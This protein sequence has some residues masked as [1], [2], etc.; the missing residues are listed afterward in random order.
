MNN[1]ALKD[2]FSGNIHTDAG[3]YLNNILLHIPCYIYWKNI[4]FVYLGC[5]TLFAKAA[6]FTSP[7]EIIGKTDYDLAWGETEADL[8]QQSDKEVLSG[9]YKL[10]F[11]EP[12][13]Q[14]DGTTKTVLASKVPML[15]QKGKIIGILGIYIDITK[16][17]QTEELEREK[18]IAEEK[19]E[20]MKMLAASIAHELRTPLAS[21]NALSGV[22]RN[23]LP[24]LIQSY[25]KALA[26]GVEVD[27]LS[28]TILNAL[29]DLPDDFN[30]IINSANTFINMLLAKVNSEKA[31]PTELMPLSIR[32]CVDKALQQYPFSAGE[33]RLIYW[34]TTQDF[35]FKGDQ[36]LMIYV[37]F[38]LLKNALHYLAVAG[39]GEIRIWIE[40]HKD[41]NLLH[42]KDTAKGINSEVLPYIFEQFY[43]KTKHGTGVG[44]AFCKMV[45]NSFGGNISCESKENEY[46]HF[47]LK[48][49]ISLNKLLL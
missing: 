1:S 41:Y 42:F 49:P 21:I 26:E 25:Q 9:K 13:L 2:Q 24:V 44:L 29:I 32:E 20:T 11:E 17:K 38:N 7:Q 36:L 31:K 43:S 37:L 16:K 3:I 48:F 47:M 39:K 45:M 40:K 18:A 5:N 12:Q 46:A 23:A 33:R 27:P 22:L 6:G 8:F 34:N 28:K 35:I 4:N 15:D 19:V 10:N 14:A 30:Q